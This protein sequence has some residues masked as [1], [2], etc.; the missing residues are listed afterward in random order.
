VNE[1]P[2]KTFI[3]LLPGANPGATVLFAM[4]H[5]SGMFANLEEAYLG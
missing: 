1:R 5:Q 3:A 4:N 2:P